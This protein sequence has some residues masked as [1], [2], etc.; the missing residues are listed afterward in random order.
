MFAHVSDCDE[1]VSPFECLNRSLLRVFLDDCE[2][3]GRSYGAG[4][5]L[6]QREDLGSAT[7]LRRRTD[8]TSPA[9][10]GRAVHPE[11]HPAQ[12]QPADQEE[13]ERGGRQT[14]HRPKA[15]AAQQLGRN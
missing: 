14:K 6:G 8:Q 1:S 2:Q 13:E 9:G 5:G 15:I 12:Q 3:R 10:S 11:H 7:G 4:A